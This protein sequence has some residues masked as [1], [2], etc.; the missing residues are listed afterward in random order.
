MINI[1]VLCMI[2][3]SGPYT[4]IDVDDYIKSYVEGNTKFAKEFLYIR[5]I[6]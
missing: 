1:I 4:P 6:G 3:N 5:K 2:K